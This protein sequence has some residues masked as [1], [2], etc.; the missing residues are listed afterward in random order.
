MYLHRIKKAFFNLSLTSKL[1]YIYIGLIFVCIICNFIILYG[2]F[3]REMQKTLSTLTSQTVETVSQN[4]NSSLTTISKTSTYL[5]GAAEVQNYLQNASHSEYAIISRQLRNFLYL[6]LES[7]PLASSIIV[8]QPSGLY[9]GVARYTLPSVQ[10]KSPENAPWY[11][12]LNAQK[13]SPILTINGGD[14]LRFEDQG[15]YVTLIRLI[16]STE[17][18]QPLGYMFIN[19]SVDSL[20]SFAREDNNNYSDFYVSSGNDTILPFLNDD[21]NMWVSVASV[22][23][24]HAENIITLNHDRYLLLKFKASEFDWNYI[25][26]IN[27]HLFTNQ[28]K[29]FIV[30][31]IVMLLVCFS[32]FLLTAIIT[33]RYVTA[34]IGQLM[35][36][37]EKSENGVFKHANVTSYYDEIGQLQN[38]YNDMVDK[39]EQLLEAKVSE[40]KRLREA[41][42]NILQEQIKP[43]F[44][45]NSL[46]AISYLVTS[47]QNDK[48]YELLISLSE[49]YRESLS[50]G[51]KIISLSTEINIVKNYLKLQK[52][53]FPDAFADEYELQNEV[54]SY[55]IPRLILQPLVENALYHGI[56]PTG[57]FGIIKIRAYIETEYLIL[58]VQDNGIGMAKAAPDK[59]LSSHSINGTSQSFGLRGTIERMQI[60]Y[61]TQ[62]I[63]TI[64][65]CPN[66]GT[67]ITFSIPLDKTEVQNEQ[68][69]S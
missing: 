28:H 42:L 67:T 39:I 53:R 21:L 57:D 41:E 24:L 46:G 27:Y 45:Y 56:I 16:N 33:N 49:Y 14:C 50:K 60:F 23:S 1:K 11:E 19:I 31:S 48:A 34:P 20:L 63:C 26:A 66:E 22:D 38:A 58:S 4:V 54:L 25:A 69:D 9:E 8:M 13:G 5:L 61:E 10:I 6:S 35:N 44:L 37:M 40:Q 64:T 30:I 68:F 32:F 36:A 51:N 65:S 52:V 15:N 12:E 29:T 43:H 17:N 2:F 18:A 62:N 7:M 59:I 55:R 3:S 47:M